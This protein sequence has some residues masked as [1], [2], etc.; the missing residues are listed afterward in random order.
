MPIL[1]YTTKVPAAK[2]VAE[3]QSKL[4]KAKAE[5]ILTEYESDGTVSAL[6]FRIKTEFGTLTFRLPANIQRVYQVLVR[7][8]RIARSQRTREQAARV[9][10]RIVKDW[11]EAQLAVI[12]AGLVD[13]EQVFLP[14]AQDQSGET[15]YELVRKQKF[16]SLL[17]DGR[18]SI[19][20]PFGRPQEPESESTRN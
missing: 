14:Y 8:A 13:L 5:A 9:A 17:A 3:I 4:A 2:T 15:F 12:E 19:G 16:V 7:D 18:A 11:L 1:D 6:S 10:W 20:E